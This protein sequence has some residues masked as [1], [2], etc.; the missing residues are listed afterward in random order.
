MDP[1]LKFEGGKNSPAFICR[2]DYI[3]LFYN[4]IGRPK[5]SMDPGCRFFI[6]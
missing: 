4:M 1:S 2:T 6:R 5:E 3:S